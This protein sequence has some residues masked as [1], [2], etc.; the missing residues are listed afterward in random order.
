M[1]VKSA[2]AGGFPHK[3]GVFWWYTNSS[4]LDLVSNI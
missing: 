1:G 2:A 3:E 4:I